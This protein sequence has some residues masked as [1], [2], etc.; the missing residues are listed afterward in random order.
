MESTGCVP[1]A[2][3]LTVRDTIHPCHRIGSRFSI[4]RLIDPHQRYKSHLIYFFP[5]NQIHFV[6]QKIPREE[7]VD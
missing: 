2:I 5:G 1:E 6:G 4:F 7:P 3:L